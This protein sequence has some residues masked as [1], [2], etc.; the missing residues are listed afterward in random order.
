M[1]DL[2]ENSSTVPD[3]HRS[4]PEISGLIKKIYNYPSDI[5][6]KIDNSLNKEI[7]YGKKVLNITNFTKKFRS[8]TIT[9]QTHGLIIYPAKFIPQIPQLCIQK[10]SD[11]HDLILDPFCGCG[12]TLVE[13]MLLQRN[14]YGLD[15]NP[16]AQL[17]T[18]VKTTPLDLTL[19]SKECTALEQFLK[20]NS[21]NSVVSEE[22]IPYFPNLSYWFTPKILQELVKLQRYIFNVSDSTIQ[23]FFLLILASI[24][25]E[26]SLADRDQLHP[27]RTKYSR[28]KENSTIQTYEIFRKSLHFRL[29]IIKEFSQYDFSEISVQVI[30]EDATKIKC[31][32]K[33]NLAVTSPPY[34]N[35]LDYVRIHK[36]EA[37]W[38]GL[39]TPKEI[40]T[41]HR[42]FIGTENVYKDYYYNLPEFSNQELNQLISQIASFDR[43]RAGI[44]ALYFTRMF[45][46]LKEV[47]QLLQP[48]GHYCIVIGSN[49]IRN[50]HVPTPKIFIQ[51]A[52][53]EIGYENTVNYSYEVIN[54]RLKIPR[55]RHGGNIKKEWIIILQKS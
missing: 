41:L 50:I 24:I 46:N 44:V 15:I 29:P 53:D 32:S 8:H 16:L 21:R 37:F 25:R 52:E 39:L 45:E 22:K 13:A 40:P 4:L 42:K 26:V 31:P 17:I 33:V 35:A 38:A 49:N 10:Y 36:L 55:A 1:S 30:E 2:K 9:Y 12:T 19:L 7:I 11:L 23:D 43:K 28:K 51:F 3:L 14:G 47:Y 48:G 54:K 27:A 34:V 18:K 5:V 6:L 20:I